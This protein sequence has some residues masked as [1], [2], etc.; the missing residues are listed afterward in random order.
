MMEYLFEIVVIALL[1]LLLL[2][3]L[4]KFYN[5]ARNRQMDKFWAEVTTY[6]RLHHLDAHLLEEKSLASVRL[7]VDEQWKHPHLTAE[8]KIKLSEMKQGIDRLSRWWRLR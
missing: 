7:F 5:W 1:A 3:L 2:L 4:K 6:A 8:V